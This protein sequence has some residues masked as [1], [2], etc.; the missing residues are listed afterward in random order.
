MPMP[1]RIFHPWGVKARVQ[2]D[3]TKRE[4][5]VSF[6]IPELAMVEM[7]TLELTTYLDDRLATVRQMVLECVK[8]FHEARDT[9]E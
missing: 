1:Q 4:I 6:R 5:V 8:K 2:W 7:T 9:E 3:K